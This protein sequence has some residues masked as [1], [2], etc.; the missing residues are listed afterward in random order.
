[1]KRTL[2]NNDD[3]DGDDNDDGAGSFESLS[4]E[5]IPHGP[6]KATSA[7]KKMKP[8]G[9]PLS[10]VTF[11]Q[12]APLKE[13]RDQ[14]GILPDDG[15]ERREDKTGDAI[16]ALYG[17]EWLKEAVAR[18]RILNASV[19]YQ[20]ARKVSGGA[21]LTIENFLKESEISRET[22]ERIAKATEA[23]INR[24]KDQQDT[25]TEQERAA[26]LHKQVEQ[27][28]AE[29]EKIATDASAIDTAQECMKNAEIVISGKRLVY[30]LPDTARP[31]VDGDARYAELFDKMTRSIVARFG[32]GQFDKSLTLF[33]TAVQVMHGKLLE[34]NA[35]DE[36]Y[37]VRINSEMPKSS[38]LALYWS[39]LMAIYLKSELLER[40]AQNSQGFFPANS[41]Y[42]K[43]PAQ[44]AADLRSLGALLFTVPDRPPTDN[45]L[46]LDEI[47]IF[48]WK[49][50]NTMIERSSENASAA[51]TLGRPLRINVEEGGA[52]TATNRRKQIIVNDI[53]VTIDIPD[54][55]LRAAV[56]GQDVFGVD[57]DK[58]ADFR[59]KLYK[60]IDQ[61]RTAEQINKILDPML[62]SVWPF[63]FYTKQPL[64]N[65]RDE[66]AFAGGYY[67][68]GRVVQLFEGISNQTAALVSVV[69]LAAFCT[70]LF[71]F[72]LKGKYRND[73]WVFLNQNKFSPIFDSIVADDGL[74]R[75]LSDTFEAV[76]SASS[77]T[78]TDYEQRLHG[79]YIRRE[80]LLECFAALAVLRRARGMT[81]NITDTD[82]AALRA[83]HDAIKA[84]GGPPGSTND[85]EFAKLE[86]AAYRAFQATNIIQGVGKTAHLQ[87]YTHTAL[88]KAVDQKYTK[89][90]LDANKER[91]TLLGSQEKAIQERINLWLGRSVNDDIKLLKNII[92]EGAGG[93]AENALSPINTGYLFFTEVYTNALQ[94]AFTLLEDH[95]PCVARIY[96]NDELIESEL[97]QTRYASLV[98]SVLRLVDARNPRT[99]RADRTEQR[100][101][102]QAISPIESIRGVARQDRSVRHWPG[103]GCGAVSGAAGSAPDYAFT[104]PYPLAPSVQVA[105]GAF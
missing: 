10:D 60:N 64:D 90:K 81:M 3:D 85:K 61:A 50:L 84:G 12:I 6:L 16:H 40:V 92:E 87:I 103:C 65:G 58:L 15:S 21:N 69:G 18:Q 8:A 82:F 47:T 63:L 43:N 54:E 95:V 28:L 67:G 99:Y 52:G 4:E 35:G 46:T 68:E 29:N 66:E 93:N 79:R 44:Y 100:A 30:K 53:P 14:F 34:G 20:F 31:L 104:T 1:M 38:E 76:F 94:D 48:F 41:V 96:T 37:R 56:L 51:P 36:T 33:K 32:A 97:Y 77:D 49:M 83:Y 23:L 39:T 89:E 27:L 42:A 5:T 98:A 102:L 75:S 17:R 73:E 78:I 26:A 62:R 25:R 2:K 57:R 74:Y 45:L 101:R 24:R 86:D 13:H 7:I 70:Y 19:I 105:R 88:N 9:A 55:D 91:A 80:R 11:V 22:R 72:S 71:N 59:N